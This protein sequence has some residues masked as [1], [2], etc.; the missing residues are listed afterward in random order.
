MMLQ[1]STL[2]DSQTVIRIA[3]RAQRNGYYGVTIPEQ[4]GS[5]EDALVVIGALSQRCDG[6]YFMT[7]VLNHHARHPLAL[8][9]SAST[10]SH[11]TSGR[12][13]L[14]L[15]TGA[16]STLQTMNLEDPHP[17]PKIGESIEIIRRHLA[18]EEVT[19]NGE[20]YSVSSAKLTHGKKRGV[21][22]IYVAAIQEKAVRF[23]SKVADGILLSNCSTPEYVQHVSRIIRANTEG[24]EFQVA[25]T[26]SYLP[27]GDRSEGL[28]SA[29][30]IAERYLM[31]PGI[32]E[33]LLS[34]SGVDPGILTE[35]RKGDRGRLTDE[36]VESMVVI[37]D[38]ERL[39][40][41]LDRLRKAGVTMPIITTLPD[42]IEQ[43]ATLPKDLGFAE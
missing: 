2:L 12:F 9:M 29:R 14:G 19:F 21:V 15:G 17:I 43:V 6:M 36:M 22:P 3:E 4:I 7:H 20:Y 30:A 25:C 42:F 31:M 28:K 40:E 16:Y 23:V 11:L 37:G 8:A 33:V 34:G 5:S 38:Q 10:L 32:G 1:I 18:G 35:M 13:I 41:R 26:V 24:R 39:V 27:V